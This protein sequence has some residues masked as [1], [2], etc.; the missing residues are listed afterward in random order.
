MYY[1]DF[2]VTLY[3]GDAGEVLKTFDDQSVQCVVTSPPY[4]RMR[5]YEVDGQMGMEETPEL[6]TEALV[7][8]FKEVW[9]VLRD[10]GTI[11][12]NLGD[13]YASGGWGNGCSDRI[14]RS[15]T[16]S[17]REKLTGWRGYPKGLKHKDL[18]GIPW[19][20]AFAMQSAGWYLRSSIIWEKPNVLPESVTDRPTKSYEYVFLMSKEP[21]Y[22]YDAD[23]VKVPSSPNTHERGQRVRTK[24]DKANKKN[25][26]ANASFLQNIGGVVKMRN[27]RDVWTIPN[28]PF[29]EAHFS[30][31]PPKLAKLCILA[32][33]PAGEVVLDP[34]IGSGTSCAVAKKFGRK[35]IG[36]DLKPEFLEMAKRRVRQDVLDLE[37]LRNVK[38]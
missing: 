24:I 26:R 30:T 35:S 38:R 11:W 31:F 13:C 18:V 19:R 8:L 1:Q 4:W 28:R 5:D 20:F 7:K 17:Q 6:Y 37:G 25:N 29:K 33:C 32:G 2:A 27:L 3:N 10:D 16:Y 23:A 14:G 15:R 36:I 22:Y 9:R 12:V 34:F 21:Q